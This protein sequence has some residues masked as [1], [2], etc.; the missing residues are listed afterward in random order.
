MY[1]FPGQPFFF[2]WDVS[3]FLLFSHYFH[4]VLLLFNVSEILASAWLLLIAK[5]LFSVVKFWTVLLVVANKTKNKKKT[6]TQKTGN[7]R[8]IPQFSN[9]WTELRVYEYAVILLRRRNDKGHDFRKPQKSFYELM[10]NKMIRTR[11]TSNSDQL[12]DQP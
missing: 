6:K 9:G 12:N 3:H 7:W 1:Y 10:Q 11:K 8:L 4:F 5:E 2:H